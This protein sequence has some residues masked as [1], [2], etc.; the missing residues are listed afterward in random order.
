MWALGKFALDKLPC[1][2]QHLLDFVGSI[3]YFILTGREVWSDTSTSKAQKRIIEGK[4]PNFPEPSG[5]PVD[6]ILR[7]AID[8]CYVYDP[9]ERPK[10]KD[11]VTFLEREF[12]KL[13]QEE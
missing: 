8:L 7:K 3:L 11:I 12:S 9:E 2:E 1:E 5:D 10:A 4:M 13:Y 6:S